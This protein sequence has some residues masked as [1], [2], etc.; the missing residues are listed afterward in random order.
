MNTRTA[1]W[2]VAGG[3]LLVATVTLVW[4]LARPPSLGN[5][6]SP[7][8]APFVRSTWLNDGSKFDGTRLAMRESAAIEVVGLDEHAVREALGTPDRIE[9]EP[10]RWWYLLGPELGPFSVDSLWLVVD[11]SVDGLA[12][13]TELTD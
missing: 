10:M 7:G 4:W 5:A 2:S 9:S 12:R 8:D 1:G 3:L 6:E 11:F 13:P